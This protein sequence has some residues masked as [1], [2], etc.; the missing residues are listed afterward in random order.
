MLQSSKEQLLYAIHSVCPSGNI[1]PNLGT[2]QRPNNNAD[3]SKIPF[4]IL[5]PAIKVILTTPST[6]LELKGRLCSVCT[7]NLLKPSRT[8]FLLNSSHSSFITFQKMGIWTNQHGLSLSRTLAETEDSIQWG[9]FS[10]DCMLALDMEAKNMCNFL[11][12]KWLAKIYILVILKQWK[13]S[14][15]LMLPRAISILSS[16]ISF[17]TNILNLLFLNLSQKM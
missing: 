9:P 4:W 2:Y 17:G 11:L 10:E 15:L 12:R 3:C 7:N 6:S 16:N 14:K 5:C 13:L 8:H 1:Y